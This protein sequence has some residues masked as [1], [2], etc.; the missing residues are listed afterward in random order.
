M[1]HS[2]DIPANFIPNPHP[3]FKACGPE[4]YGYYTSTG[5]YS[6]TDL[7]TNPYNL[8]GPYADNVGSGP[9]EIVE[10]FM[11]CDGDRY[12]TSL[13]TP[14]G[15]MEC[16][17]AIPTNPYLLEGSY[18]NDGGPGPMSQE[19]SYDSEMIPEDFTLPNWISSQKKPQPTSTVSK[20]V[21]KLPTWMKGKEKFTL[22]DMVPQM[23]KWMIMQ[24]AQEHFL[25]PPVAE[26]PLNV[27]R[28]EQCVPAQHA[29]DIC[30][31][32]FGDEW[33]YINQRQGSCPPGSYHF[34]CTDLKTKDIKV[35][36]AQQQYLDQTWPYIPSVRAWRILRY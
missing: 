8:R 30:W 14:N 9:T 35:P 36:H 23:P 33:R 19:I 1:Y 13:F 3:S 18:R 26:Y 20:I 10:N 4:R 24:K 34:E 2:Q 28:T 31:R 32:Q 7:L 22:D 15:N 27:M 11:D 6:K 17:T 5:N 29:D 21:S 25:Y 16:N 12:N